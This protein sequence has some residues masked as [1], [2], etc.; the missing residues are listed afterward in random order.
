[1]AC[2]PSGP[3]IDERELT[4]KLSELPV[5]GFDEIARVNGKSVRLSLY[6]DLRARAPK[7][8]RDQI[9]WVAIVAAEWT[10][11]RTDRAPASDDA[12]ALALYAVGG[13]WDERAARAAKALLIEGAPPDPKI[14]A[15]RLQPIF[16]RAQWTQ[17]APLLERL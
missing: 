13:E 4:Q 15:Q 10:S 1:M 12:L 16:E 7:A 9:L 11:S 8:S 14:V 5:L 17:N 3:K 6:Q 2:T